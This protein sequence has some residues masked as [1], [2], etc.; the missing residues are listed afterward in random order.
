[1]QSVQ[2]FSL[3][4]DKFLLDLVRKTIKY[5]LTQSCNSRRILFENFLKTLCVRFPEVSGKISFN[6][7]HLVLFYI[8]LN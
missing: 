8:N 2:Y 6:L 3:K 7:K 4:Q 5:Q 1:M